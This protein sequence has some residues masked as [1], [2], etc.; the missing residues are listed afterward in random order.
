MNAGS[1][2]QQ[3][4]QSLHE[5][6]IAVDHFVLLLRR[7]YD[8]CYSVS[9][10]TILQLPRSHVEDLHDPKICVNSSP[11]L[12]GHNSLCCCTCCK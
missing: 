7:A 11:M 4:E 10:S 5:L 8:G 2:R 1:I 9:T 12:T 3:A 6:S